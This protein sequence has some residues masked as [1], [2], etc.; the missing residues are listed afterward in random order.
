MCN[1][2]PK[3]ALARAQTGLHSRG[4]VPVQE[5]LHL[6]ELLAIQGSPKDERHSQT[7]NLRTD[8]ACTRTRRVGP[9]CVLADKDMQAE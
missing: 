3:T 4:T 9:M 2:G 5:A 8:E 6:Q 1:P 7:G